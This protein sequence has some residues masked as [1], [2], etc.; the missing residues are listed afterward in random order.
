MKYS[1]EW[2]L[3]ELSEPFY[4]KNF[5]VEF[6]LSIINNNIDN[7]DNIDI[8]YSTRDNTTEIMKIDYSKIPWLPKDIKN[9]LIE[10][11]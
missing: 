3:L 7:I 4:F 11:L 8:I 9:F 5:F 2:E 10:S 1:N 6:S